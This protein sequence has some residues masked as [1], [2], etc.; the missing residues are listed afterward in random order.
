MVPFTENH[1]NVIYVN[2]TEPNPGAGNL[3]GAA[4]KFGNCTG[5]AGITRAA[6]HWKNF[7][8]RVGLLL[9]VESED[10]APGRFL[11]HLLWTWGAYEYGTSTVANSVSSLQNGQFL[12]GSTGTNVPGYGSWDGNPMPL[13]QPTPFSPTIANGVTI[14]RLQSQRHRWQEPPYDQAWN[15]SVQ[16]QLPWNMF[17]T[18]AYVGNRAVHLTDHPGAVQPAQPVGAAVWQLFWENMYFSRCRCRRHHRFP[19]RVTCSSMAASAT[20]EQALTPFPQF[21]AYFPCLEIGWNRILQ[22]VPGAGGEAIFQW[23]ELSHQPYVV[24]DS[25]PMQSSDRTTFSP[26]GLERI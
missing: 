2:P 26:N 24:D 19:F 8:P 1:N 11:P 3:P 14:L 12:R 21:G 13:P 4:T 16:R 5:C 10:R 6:I 9:P 22:C 23:R 20:V 18:A 25:W 7:Q 17:L 15:I